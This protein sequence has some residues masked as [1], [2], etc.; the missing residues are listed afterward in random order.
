MPQD[1]LNSA[2]QPVDIPLTNGQLLYWPGWLKNHLNLFETLIGE[3]PWEQPKIR[4]AGKAVAIPRLQVW[5]GD[6]NARMQYSGVSFTPL[7]WHPEIWAVKTKIEKLTHS[8]FNSVLVN[9]YRT[10]GDSVGWHSDNEKE[11]GCNPVIASL[12]L[13]ASRRFGLKPIS[14]SDRPIYLPLGHGDLLVMSAET[15]QH[16]QHSIPKKTSSELK[17]EEHSSHFEK[18]RINLTF[19]RIVGK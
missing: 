4:I 17:L 18:A 12:S 16:W 15:Q 11:L 10:G 7:I 8:S 2:D 9:L 13:G 6:P 3:L 1:L 14:S 5:M 19:R